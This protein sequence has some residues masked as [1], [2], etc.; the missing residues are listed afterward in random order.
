MARDI[1][2]LRRS[3]LDDFNRDSKIFNDNKF[4]QQLELNTVLEGLRNKGGMERTKFSTDAA[5]KLTKIREEGQ[6][7]RMQMGIDNP[8]NQAQTAKLMQSMNMNDKYGEDF[9]KQMFEKGVLD[10]KLKQLMY[11]DTKSQ[12]FPEKKKPE[13]AGVTLPESVDPVAADSFTPNPDLFNLTDLI[14]GRRLG[15]AM[16]KP[17]KFTD[18]FSGLFST[19]F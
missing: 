19:Q 8:L 18:F 14:P 4:Q 1:M 15:K 13:E 7:R 11:D 3:V 6:T 17:N 2:S 12:L 16:R 5:E 9:I 10:N